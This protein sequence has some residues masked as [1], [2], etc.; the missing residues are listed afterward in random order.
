MKLEGWGN[1]FVCVRELFIFIVKI[2]PWGA[3]EKVSML[4]YNRNLS[5]LR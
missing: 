1:Y 2:I 4:R 5:S 3:E